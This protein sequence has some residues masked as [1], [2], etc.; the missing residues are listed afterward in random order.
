MFMKGS[1]GLAVGILLYGLIAGSL[2]DYIARPYL[3]SRKAQTHTLIVF[4]GIFGG[5]HV[6]GMPGIVVGPIVLSVA[7]AFIKDL[8]LYGSK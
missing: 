4:L 5:L 7:G 3:F 6:L 1:I 2:L 8:R